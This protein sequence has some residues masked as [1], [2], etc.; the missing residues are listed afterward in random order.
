MDYFKDN[1]WAEYLI[2][3]EITPSLL[4]TWKK[5]N[6]CPSQTQFEDTNNDDFLAI[7]ATRAASERS[8][9]VGQNQT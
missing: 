4:Q 3:E 7:P 9:S 5:Y 1:N 6:V 8:F 2:Q